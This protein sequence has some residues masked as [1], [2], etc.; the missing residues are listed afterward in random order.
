MKE[1]VKMQKE[2]YEMYSSGNTHK[3]RS[4][5]MCVCMRSTKIRGM[6]HRFK[7]PITAECSSDGISG[8]RRA[9]M[10]PKSSESF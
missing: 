8:T 3:Q 10:A 9:Q 1:S 5:C 7:V 4:V 2:I 6:L